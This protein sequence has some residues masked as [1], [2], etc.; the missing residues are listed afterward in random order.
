MLR[1]KPHGAIAI[2]PLASFWISD[3]AE[4]NWVR[5]NGLTAAISHR[6]PRHMTET[7]LPITGY[8]DSFSHRPGETFTAFVSVR[9]GGAY[10]GILYVLFPGSRNHSPRT[11]AEIEIEGE[12]LVSA[13]GG[14]KKL[15]SCAEG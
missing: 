6:Q 1:P 9:D 5:R 12:K 7:E 15:Y 14:I 10:R 11:I 4:V 8:L 3:A 13:I 2:G